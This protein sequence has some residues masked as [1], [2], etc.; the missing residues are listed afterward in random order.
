[1]AT[2]IKTLGTELV[3]E[4]TSKTDSLEIAH[5]RFIRIRFAHQPNLTRLAIKRVRITT[6]RILDTEAVWMKYVLQFAIFCSEF[7][8]LH[9]K[10]FFNA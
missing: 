1:M 8:V 3:N 6:Y 10:P 4:A 7:S 2:K 9:F 5:I